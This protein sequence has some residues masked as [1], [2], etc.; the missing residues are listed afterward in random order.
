MKRE[1]GKC[2]ACCTLLPV[3]EL[4][5]P[6]LHR[7]QHQSF[8]RGCK[9]YDD[10]ER[11]LSCK[12]WTCR[13][14]TGNDTADLPRPDRAHYVIDTFPDGIG[15]RSRDTG[16]TVRVQVVQIWCDPKY[17]EAH[18]DPA[19]RAYIERRG[20]EGIAALVRYGS[21]DG[22]VI[23]A[24]KVSPTGDWLEVGGGTFRPPEATTPAAV[25]GAI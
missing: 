19:L 12:L 10:P 23:F 25:A 11:P 8:A 14:L 7:C 2:T 15:I 24:P 18:R 6:A 4:S 13:W 17:P 20:A 3:L 5:K 16:E 22:L 21:R 9:I 1:C